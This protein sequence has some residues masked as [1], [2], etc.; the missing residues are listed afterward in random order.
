MAK[1]FVSAMVRAGP[2][3]R[4]W[5]AVFAVAALV[6]GLVAAV[7]APVSASGPRDGATYVALGDSYSSGEGLG[8]FQVGTNVSG[9][10][11]K[12]GAKVN[13]CHRADPGAYSELKSQIV[14]PAVGNRAFWAC[15]GSTVDD[16]YTTPAPALNK[17][18]KTWSG[19]YNQPDQVDTV[20]PTTKYIT[21]SVG[22]NDI[23]FGNLGTACGDVAVDLKIVHRLSKT[24]CADQ[25]K[26]AEGTLR[27]KLAVSS[28]PTKG[29]ETDQLVGLYETL[30][31]E[32]APGAKL[33]VV[34]YP[35]VFRAKYSGLTK[36]AGLGYCTLDDYT[37]PLRGLGLVSVKVGM[38][39]GDA[40]DLGKLITEL[41]NTIAAA[42]S[43][44]A[45]AYPG[46]IAF[47]D[48][49]AT[50]VSRNCLG[51][52][53]NA[54]VTGFELALNG[55][56]KGLH[57]LVSSGTFHPTTAG[58]HMFAQQVQDAFER[59]APTKWAETPVAADQLDAVTCVGT[60][61]CL[62][63]D[64]DGSV[65]TSTSP[66]GRD[67][68][69]VGEPIDDNQ[70][71]AAMTCPSVSLR[72]V[73][74]SDGNILISTDPTRA[75]SWSTSF[76]A[77]TAI[78]GLSCPSISFCEAAGY[79]GEVFTTTRPAGG[80]W[81]E[82]DP[83]PG[84]TIY[85]LDCP[86]P[87]LCVAVDLAGNIIVSHDPGGG[88]WGP[89]QDVDASTGIY[90][91]SCPSRSFC[92]AEDSA[93]NVIISTD[94]VAAVP[95]WKVTHIDSGGY[96]GGGTAISCAS[97]Q[98]CA[99]GDDSGNI[100]TT[101]DPAGGAAAWR[102]TQLTSA[103]TFGVDCVTATTCVAVDSAGRAFYNTSAFSAGS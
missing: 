38:P 7:A 99:M 87:S 45:V 48:T 41:N 61:L 34:G 10:G 86:A 73:G 31:K 22:G 59:L 47:A 91:V 4:R 85:G 95:V 103:R 88:L 72:L 23:G 66:T 79:D 54:T 60:R 25:V 33:V 102:V 55:P 19:D 78:S 83:D 36:V 80:D 51:Y 63:G 43:D 75:A 32:A 93:G 24:S 92:A 28:P 29:H 77:S 49:A 21:L 62:S 58:Q 57:R 9:N 5:W 89:A 50:S 6:A 52:T 20:G 84:N 16:M 42:V 56:G 2:A 53:A 46:Q 18:R 74:D 12:A 44:V 96:L 71:N 37:V 67:P 8:H 76:T 64:L 100:L 30:L 40:E 94:P 101:V 68:A 81:T 3:G 39:I 82:S 35:Q 97:A 26:T 27:T 13:Q 14:L 15:A 1:S 98:L 65:Y 69:W 17:K 70:I 90:S 11:V